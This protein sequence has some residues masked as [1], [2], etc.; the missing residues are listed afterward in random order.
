MTL[1]L[2]LRSLL[3]QPIRATVLACGFGLGIGAM[4]GLMG[5][6]EVIVEQSRSPALRGGGDVVIY[7]TSGAVSSARFLMAS[8][9]ATPVLED[10]AR[11]VSPASTATLYWLDEG[12]K[13]DPVQVTG[14]IPSLER[15]L[16]DAETA[17]V[18]AWVDRAGDEAWTE[19]DPG[20]VLRAM[21]RFHAIPPVPQRAATWAEWLYFNGRGPAGEAFYLTFLTGPAAGEGGRE[22]GVRLQLKWGGAVTAYF[23]H[24]VVDGESLLRDAPD[25]TI[26]SSSVR[27][28]GLDYH[29]HLELPAEEGSGSLVGDLV[30]RGVPG[31]SLPPLQVRGAGGWISGYVVPVTQG[32][33]AGELRAGRDV[34]S[35]DGGTGYHDHNWGFW[36]GVTW[37]WGQV[38]LG[39]LSLVYGRIRPPADAFDPER[40]PGFLVV[41][42]P[43]GL[44]GQS[45]NVDIAQTREHAGPPSA[46][47]VAARSR[48]LVVDLELEVQ[49]AVQSRF[50][51]GPLGDG[52]GLVFYQMRALYRVSGTVGTR[53]IE[54]TAP[55]SAETFGSG[56]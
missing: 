53:R 19:P 21:D 42:G 46:I 54:F 29:L 43:D 27:L 40:L 52:A 3:S 45:S 9:F 51:R 48:G 23:D 32:E 33:L 16:G 44:L 20:E 55:G 12:A 10:R 49:D 41:L 11:V 30:L 34:V 56:P 39:D 38:A 22:A 36:G 35:F 25:L 13:P 5:I 47:R 31:R 14:G 17:G 26:G 18:E 4:T 8:L 7:G 50:E 24:A 2:A 6:G 28:V 1:L 37:Q 15:A